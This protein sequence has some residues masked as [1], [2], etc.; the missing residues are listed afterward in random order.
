MCLAQR[1]RSTAMTFFFICA[2]TVSVGP[3]PA[4]PARTRPQIL[5]APDR[6]QISSAAAHPEFDT[7]GAQRVAAHYLRGCRIP[8]TSAML[9][10]C[11]HNALDRKARR[12]REGLLNRGC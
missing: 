12:K 3:P 10:A 4:D 2:S 6:M 11:P 7:T 9:R 5:H 1:R 8:C